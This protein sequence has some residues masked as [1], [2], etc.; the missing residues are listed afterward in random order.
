MVEMGF[1]DLADHY[2]SVDA[3]NALW[4]RSTQ[5]CPGRS[6]ARTLSGS[7]ASRMRSASQWTPFQCSRRW[8]CARFTTCP[9]TRSSI[10]CATGCLSCDSWDGPFGDCVPTLIFLLKP[11]LFYPARKTST[12]KRT[13]LKTALK[14]DRSLRPIFLKCSRFVGTHQLGKKHPPPQLS[15]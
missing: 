9:T 11:T 13:T 4:S 14:T 3:K 10:R 6:S 7:G 2:A 8:C 12:N 5:W 1:F 15:L